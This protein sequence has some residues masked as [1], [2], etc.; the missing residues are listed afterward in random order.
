MLLARRQALVAS[1][2]ERLSS[3]REDR[4]R[5]DHVTALDDGEVC[6]LDVQEDIEFALVQ[7]KRETLVH[8]DAALK[9]LDNGLYGRCIDCDGEISESRLKALPFAVRCVHCEEARESDVMHER[10]R[11]RKLVRLAGMTVLFMAISLNVFAQS[12][13]PV[14]G[15]TGTI[16][17]EGT[18]DQETKAVNAL[19]VKTVDGTR[20]V[21]HLAKDVVVHGSRDTSAE[22]LKNLRTGTT[23]VVHYASAGT[24]AAIHEIDIVGD[25]GLKTTEG[26]VVG[27]NRRKHE[28]T[29]RLDNATTEVLQLSARAARD[30]GHEVDSDAGSARIVLYY[31]DDGG[32]K[33]AHYFRRVK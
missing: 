3:V 8:L 29:V 11:E 30:V 19:A 14:P 22:S 2:R 33:V 18:I 15:A 9:R 21:F 5:A 4:S 7:M 1:I 26:I 10:M 31:T 6:D 25:D 24:D 27:I 16:A 28:I 32:A 23:V 13:P 20:R 17:L 12:T